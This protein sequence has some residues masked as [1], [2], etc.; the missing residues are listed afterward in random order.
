MPQSADR[1]SPVTERRGGITALRSAA[2]T[3][4]PV[5]ICT[6]APLMWSVTFSGMQGR[7]FSDALRQ[8]WNG[9]DLGGAVE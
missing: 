6:G 9:V 4:E 5:G 2:E 3:T 7:L 1:G 8:V